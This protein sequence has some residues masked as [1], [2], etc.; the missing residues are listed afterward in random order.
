MKLKQSTDGILNLVSYLQM[1]PRNKKFITDLLSDLVHSAFVTI[2]LYLVILLTFYLL[3]STDKINDPSTNVQLECIINK[4]VSNDMLHLVTFV[5]TV[6]NKTNHKYFL[7]YRS[8]YNK[9]K[10]K[11]EFH[12]MNNLDI[13]LYDQFISST[14]IEHNLFTSLISNDF[15]YK[16]ESFKK[17]NTN[18]DYSLNRMLGYYHLKLNKSNVFIYLF[19]YSPETKYEFESVRRNGFMYIQF[20][21][22][23]RMISADKE[24]FQMPAKI[25]LYMIEN[26]MFKAKIADSY[27][28]IPNDAY[29][30]LMHTY[31]NYW[32]KTFNCSF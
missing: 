25:P 21:Y 2:C 3:I 11:A 30:C 10:L 9:L 19:V 17:V 12:D 22:L 31:P 32:F 26:E 23:G 24:S 15:E 28:S 27:I 18:F 20:D 14:N 6:L 4:K 5:S 8:L 13:C 29:S 1:K 16:L 7:C